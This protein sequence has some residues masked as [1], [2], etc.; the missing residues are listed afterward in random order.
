MIVQCVAE[1]LDLD[2]VVA[3]EHDRRA[4]VRQASGKGAHVSRAAG[5]E[6]ARRL[7]EEEQPRS[8]QERSGQAET[9]A[10]AGRVAR[11]RDV[12][13][14]READLREG[15]VDSAAPAGSLVAVET[16]QQRQVPPSGQ[17]RIERGSVDE[18]GDPVG[19]RSR[20]RVRPAAEETY[21][22]GV[23]ADESKQDAQQRGFPGAVRAEE[24]VQP[25]GPRGE[26]YAGEGFAFPV[27]L[28]YAEASGRIALPPTFI[29]ILRS[30]ID[31]VTFSIALSAFQS[32][33]VLQQRNNVATSCET[34]CVHRLAW[35]RPRLCFFF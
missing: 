20:R 7:V 1:L 27:A 6:R 29:P 32:R 14:R 34:G 10:H 11:H 35:T 23:A 15:V 17:V 22:A 25:A 12:R 8:A 16:G 21:G 33:W 18:A 5:V 30:C 2:H 4:F 3:A 26:V 28:G 9:L 19:Y 31:C 13:V 24:P